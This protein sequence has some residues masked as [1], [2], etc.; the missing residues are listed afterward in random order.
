MR[1]AYIVIACIV[2]L[3]VAATVVGRRTQIERPIDWLYFASGGEPETLNPVKDYP[4]GGYIGLV[5]EPLAQRDIDTLEWK[6]VLATHWEISDDGLAYTFT[7]RHGVCWH[8][9]SPFTADDVLYTWERMCVDPDVRTLAGGDWGGCEACEVLDDHT[10]RFRWSKPYFR[11]FTLC[12]RFVPVS[13]H[14][15]GNATGKA[16]N[17]HHTQ[18]RTP[19]GTG[20]YRVAAWETARRI[21][22]ERGE[23]YWGEQPFFERII[24]V[25]VSEDQAVYQ[26]FKKGDTDVVTL[27]TLRWTKL[28]DSESFKRRFIKTRC[29][30][31][32]YSFIAWNNDRVWFRDQRVRRAMAYLVDRQTILDTIE[33]GLGQVVS[34]PLCPWS[35]AYD[36]TIEPLP[37]DPEAAKR[38][39][40]DAGWIDH[41]GDGI[42]D[43]VIDGER[44]KFDFELKVSGTESEIGVI[45]KEELRKAGIAMRMR[46]LEWSVYSVDVRER[47][48]DATLTGEGMD[49]DLDLYPMW[50][51][52]EA[53]AKESA[54][55]A[56]FRNGEVDA[57]VEKIRVTLDEAERIP[58][59]HRFHAIMHEEQPYTFLLASDDMRAYNRRLVN[60]RFLP[61]D[62]PSDVTQWRAVPRDQIDHSIPAVQIHSLEPDE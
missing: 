49:L 24:S 38:L 30:S 52:S 47:N 57:L 41:D 34:G 26:I 31:R 50:H 25:F 8:D 40:D 22:L 61:F 62:P 1:T 48:Y 29:P 37:Y 33:F 2:A 39:L 53:D 54:N 9:G 60:V 16:F 6:P 36:K 20:P 11:A 5:M 10:V 4:S 58:L 27:G 42:R 14:A 7:L 28:S 55:Y 21:V 46:H 45:L 3:A 35:P 56:N 23:T 13:R 18:N 32:W 12:A 17:D 19:T 59:Y 43:K 51:S 44:V 15:F